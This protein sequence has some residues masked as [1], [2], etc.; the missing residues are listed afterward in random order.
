MQSIKSNYTSQKKP[1][2]EASDT[3]QGLKSN[4]V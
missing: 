3:I 2:G 4:M 1:K